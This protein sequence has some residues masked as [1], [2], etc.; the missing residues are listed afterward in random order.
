MIIRK[1]NVTTVYNY[2]LPSIVTCVNEYSISTYHCQN[3]QVH[4]HP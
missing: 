4:L 1:E 3:H 2:Q